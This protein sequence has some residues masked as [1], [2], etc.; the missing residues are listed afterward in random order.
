[1][2]RFVESPASQQEFFALCEGTAFGCKLEAVARAYGFARPFARFWVGGGAA[3]C[4]LDGA[5]SLAGMP[6]DP[7]EAWAFARAVDAEVLFTPAAFPGD[8]CAELTAS[9]QVLAKSLPESEAAPL[10]EPPRL[11][12]IHRLLHG[13]GMVGEFEPFYLDLSHRIRHGAALAL[14]EYRDGKLAGCGVVSAVTERAALLSALAVDEGYRRQGIGSALVRRIETLLPGRTLYLMRE[15][16]KNQTFYAGLGFCE[17]G[18]WAQWAFI[19][20]Q[21]SGK[22]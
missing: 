17:V 11:Q 10:P 4:L 6:E 2:I 7:G 8:V 20:A 9:G 14:G 15:D 12:D 5:L 22:E 21:Y 19:L 16:N 1:M 18:R 3:Y 13:A